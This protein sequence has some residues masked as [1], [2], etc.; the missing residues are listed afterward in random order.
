MR[1]V[2]LAPAGP[3]VLGE[4]DDFEGG[5]NNWTV[6]S[7]GGVATITGATYQSAFNA[8]SINGGVVTVDSNATDTNT[9]NFQGISL[10]IRRGSDAFS[11]DPDTGEDLVVEYRRN[12]GTWVTL[13]TFAG[14]GTAGEV[15]TPTYNLPGNARH[16]NFQVRL[17]MTGG[18][19]A[20]WDFWHVD[21]VCLLQNNPPNLAVSKTVE[22]VSDGFSSTGFEKAIPGAIVR[23]TI[24]LTNSGTGSPDTGSILLA[25]VIDADHEMF[26]GDYAGVGSGPVEFIDGPGAASSGLSYTFSALANG[27]DDIE[28][29]Q[30]ATLYTPAPPYDPNVTRFRVNPKGKMNG[31]SGGTNPF[32]TIRFTARIKQ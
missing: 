3:L 23:Y 5:L 19:G 6:S 8:L 22:V 9:N 20:A 28:F 32:F 18:S 14:N 24:T 17:R 12:N 10:W 21:D 15:F 2:E 25:D 13:G 27:S 4:C 31:R 16:A 29:Y 7:S 30:G 1:V 26:V 11:E